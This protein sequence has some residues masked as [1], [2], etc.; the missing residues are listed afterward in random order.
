MPSDCEAHL[1]SK[2]CENA[3]DPKWYENS[4]N[5]C[6]NNPQC[7]PTSAEGVKTGEKDFSEHLCLVSLKNDPKLPC[8]FDI[9]I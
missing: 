6:A 9:N 7:F 2:F 1:S 5:S 3:L 8:K 4:Y